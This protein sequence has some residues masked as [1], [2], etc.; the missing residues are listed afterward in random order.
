MLAGALTVSR[1]W[2][3]GLAAPAAGSPFA[4]PL[5]AADLD[6][7]A[8]VEWV[9]GREKPVVC[10]Q[11][12]RHVVWTTT[13]TPE[14][15]GVAFG[16]SKTPGLRHVRIGWKAPVPAGAI[17]VRAGGALSVLK[18]TAAYP[19]RLDED[20]DWLP[21]ERLK[22]GARVRDEVGREDYAVW[23][24]PPGTATR[25]L[26]F[27]HTAAPI[28]KSYVG[29]LGGAYVLGERWANVAPL[30]EV[31]ACGN[32][33][34]AGKLNNESQDGT[35]GA[36]DNTPE[37]NA[38][39]ISAG[40]PAWLLLTWPRPVTLR[41]LHALWAGFRAVEAQAFSGPA[42]VHPRDATAADWQSLG[43]F[44]GVEHQYPRALG[45][46]W[47]DFGREVS[48]RAVRLRITQ[49]IDD[50]RTHP[51]IVGKAMGGRRVW[52]GELLALQPLGRADLAAVLAVGEV[53]PVRHPPI[54]IR[55]KLP[56]EGYVTLVI[57]DAAGRR[58]RNLVAETHFPAGENVVWWDGTDDL[59]RDP[60]AAR[61][62]VYRVPAH[63]VPPGA[64]RVGGLWRRALELRYE[65]S[66][67]N[68][69]T[70]AWETADGTGAWLA[71]HT[72]P[73][74]ALC[75]PAARAPGGRALVYLGS[76]VSEGGHG[77][78]WVDLDG[79]KQGGVGWVGGNWTGAAFLAHDA[80][81]Q[82]ATN[83]AAYALAPWRDDSAGDKERSRRGEI[84]L[85]A[86]GTQGQRPVCKY[87]FTPSFA[88][89]GAKAGDDNW[90][91]EVGGLAAR[92]GLLAFTLTKLNRLVLVD[93]CATNRVSTHDIVNPRGL[94]F[95]ADGSLLVVAGRTL[96]RFTFEARSRL[97]PAG[98]PLA[99]VDR[100]LDDPRQLTLD[101]A[102]NLYVGDHGQSHQV[103]VFAPDGG[104]LRAIG[105]P[106]PPRAGRYDERH[107]NRPDGLTIDAQ[108]RLW[109]AENDF[110]PKR[111]S[112]WTLDGR[113]VRAFYGPGAYGGGGKLD[114]EDP[115]RFYYNGMEFRLDWKRGADRLVGVF[116]RPD[117]DAPVEGVGPTASGA[118]ETPHR[119]Q[120]RTYFSNDHDA[121]PTGGASVTLLW[122]LRED[123]ARPVAAMGRAHEWA[124]LKAEA[125]KPLWPEGVDLRGDPWRNITAFT[126]SDLDGDAQVQTNEVQFRKGLYGTAT[127]APDLSMV[128]SR[129]GS[130]A[131]RFAPRRF[132]R[133]GA[134]VYDLGAG[135]V[136][137]RDTQNPTSSGG[138]QALWHASGW[139]VLTT[140][141]RP[142][143]PLAVGGVFRG[144]PRWSYPSLW[145]GLHASHESPPPAFPGML[146]GTTRLLGDFITPRRGEAGPL[147]C[148]NGN[149]G[150]LYLFT[151]DGLFVAELF[152]D[153]RRGPLWSMPASARGMLLNDLSLHD[154][155]FWPTL[156]QTRDGRVYLVDGARMSLVRLDGLETIRRLPGTTLTLSA[157]DLAGARSAFLEAEA[158]R[159]QRQG[160]G[161]L[162]VALRE[163][164]PIVD[165]AL[166]DW[167][168]A[169]WAEI[170]R[171]GV[172][173]YFDSRSKP[174]DVRGAVAVAGDRLYAA[175]RTGDER[176]LANSGQV[177]N[178]L[179]KTGGALD[180]MLG[181]D[182][183]ADARRERPVGGDLRLL[184]T[185]VN[186]QTA[187]TLYRAVVPGTRTPVPFSSP[188]RTITLDS[189][190]TVG[191]QVQLAGAD[192]NYEAS[193]PL[194]LLELKPA[195]GLRLKGDIGILRGNAFQTVQR[196]YWANKASGITAD[197]PSEAELTPRL[198]GVWE[199]G[200]VGN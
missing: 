67:Y 27:T 111:V 94:A 82:A 7:A 81:P 73:S 71:N 83:V 200:T 140:P 62:G 184:V 76:F 168:G 115:E 11:G 160:G 161:V 185:R 143:S 97:Q 85:T 113:L 198:W 130:A 141:P 34:Q 31:A 56:E 37:T 106:G 88:A 66:V 89:A 53:A 126:W 116:H 128:V 87:A 105:K 122:L 133:Q 132:T 101:G 193:V 57:D 4:T 174:Y 144:E 17:L 127:V 172:A 110:Q 1:S 129:F 64:Y 154:E 54:P 50:E 45:G 151:A 119:V 117:A 86:I 93:T 153:V 183:G 118:P 179:F 35:W 164:P 199:F 48:V 100:H 14:W 18:S 9:D 23:V 135:E 96:R 120:G 102:G 46:N 24:L 5:T 181:V 167:T 90:Y 26:R 60:E 74:A 52:L 38:P 75:V 65:F 99:S 80:G 192:G 70:P 194:A 166:D 6:A 182:V 95:A 10:K 108:D 142:F 196:V 39:A 138:D 186:G 29:W 191:G 55:F 20:A 134:P 148:V 68:A 19:G 13:T 21:A 156:T 188:W 145:P 162:R 8:F 195:A 187:A 173:A 78:A 22:A 175:W 150:N 146:I 189:V 104:F 47:L 121:N 61:H 51:H 79:R 158:V 72:P 103:K 84:R 33:A 147:W 163:R 59:L 159:Q 170:D 137:A 25:A 28:D 139:T 63:F 92:D 165:G 91:A 36:W 41:G 3:D 77:L 30:A 176:L 44:A 114:P 40:A 152:K 131:V 107:M 58:V 149:Q 190:E 136:L 178:A 98:P 109:V 124:C 32:Q 125:F 155:N 197:V 169:E 171:S 112:V 157:E 123:V 177:S 69:G 16:E 42:D 180:L 43:S 49:A 15:N 2:A 12:P